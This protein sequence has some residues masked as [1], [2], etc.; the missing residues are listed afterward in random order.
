MGKKDGWGQGSGTLEASNAVGEVITG[1]PLAR[2]CGGWGE[3]QTSVY[4]CGKTLARE[5]KKK[6]WIGGR[7]Y[8][9][10][11]VIFPPT[12][13]PKINHRSHR[14][15]KR[16]CSTR[17]NYRRC[18]LSTK[19]GQEER[20]ENK[21]EK[22]GSPPIILHLGRCKRKRGLFRLVLAGTRRKSGGE[23]KSREKEK[24]HPDAKALR[25][26]LHSGSGEEGG[27]PWR[28]VLD[29]GQDNREEKKAHDKTGR[30]VIQVDYNRGV[31]KRGKKKKTSLTGN[32]A[33][34]RGKL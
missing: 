31:L 18:R 32:A 4:K 10:E 9:K 23:E 8:R 14:S 26:A 11:N 28:G 6:G 24:P 27:R 21:H 20:G 25:Q 29:A 22:T 16:K 17:G 7:K 15:W 13:S 2:P 5:K 34:K 33:G 30:R 12:Y 3:R 1:A 19:K